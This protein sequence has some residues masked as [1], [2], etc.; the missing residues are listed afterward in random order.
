MTKAR[1]SPKRG[2]TLIELLVVIAI[3]AV[4]I[5]LLLP[6]VQQA[7]EA[8]RRSQCKNNL[9]QI[10][11]AMHNYHEQFGTYPPG[12]VPAATLWTNCSIMSNGTA[13][14][15]TNN[16]A[17]GW[18]TFL[19][20]NLDQAPLYDLL[21]P[22][23]CRMP[24][25]NATYG[26]QT[27]LQQPIP[28]YVCPSDPGAPIATTHQSYTKSNYMI[29]EAMGD[30]RTRVKERD[31]TDGL[32]NTMMHA[33]RAFNVTAPVGKRQTGGIAFG[34][35]NTTDAGFKFRV[36]W[37]IN[38][39]SPNNDPNSATNSD[40]GCVRHV[41]SSMHSGGAHVLMGDGSVRFVSENIGHNPAAG[42]T[43]T[44]ITMATSLAGPG[45]VLQNLFFINDRNPV[46]DF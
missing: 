44:C 38:T 25:A 16:R 24:N 3:I 43:T 28:A 37:P 32:S 36:S 39:P 31:V 40:A 2:F 9:K 33:E 14:P 7:R 30:V 20:P 6:A 45:F 26:T 42:S 17:W 18:G 35:S 15:D 46:G 22:D 19:L 27:P 13:V 4:L 29:S 23:G 1:S 11:I 5:A 21:K 41:I 34:R 10:G 12:I 8:A